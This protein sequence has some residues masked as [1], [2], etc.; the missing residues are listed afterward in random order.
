MTD[1]NWN[2][3]HY[4]SDWLKFSD[5]KASIILTV[6]GIIIT[7]IYS[8]SNDIFTAINTSKPLLILS[9]ICALMSLVSIFFSFM[10]INPNLKNPNPNSII[11]FG[12]I[13]TKYDSFDAYHEEFLRVNSNDQISEQINEQI[14]TNSKIAWKKFFH[15]SWSIRFFVLTIAILLIQVIIYLSTNL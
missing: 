1:Q 10:C 3:L 9:I 6:Y 4:N 14:Y 12:H 5:T 2:I 15:V 13:A 11:Y 8:N 7:I